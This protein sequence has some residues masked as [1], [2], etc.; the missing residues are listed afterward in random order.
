MRWCIELQDEGIAEVTNLFNRLGEDTT[1][2][3]EAESIVYRHPQ[4]N[5]Y[6]TIPLPYPACLHVVQ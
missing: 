3:L 1:N 2:P 5:A 6:Y 4:I